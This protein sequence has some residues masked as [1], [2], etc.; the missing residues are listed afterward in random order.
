MEYPK[1]VRV[2]YSGGAE[3]MG[4]AIDPI[5]V[6]VGPMGRQLKLREVV[7]IDG[8]PHLVAGFGQKFA[9]DGAVPA[10]SDETPVRL[11]LKLIPDWAI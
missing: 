6:D 11:R 2:V 3:E 4:T 1:P 8:V 7:Q 10:A 5:H 9:R